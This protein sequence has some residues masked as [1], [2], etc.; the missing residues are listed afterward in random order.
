LKSLETLRSKLS[1]GAGVSSACLGRLMPAATQS[2]TG[3]A[4]GTD[5]GQSQ[6]LSYPCPCCGGRMIVI[7]TFERGGA[8]RYRPP[9]AITIDTS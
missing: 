3:G 5:G 2:A 9:A 8:P 7:E 4:D 6:A 1:R